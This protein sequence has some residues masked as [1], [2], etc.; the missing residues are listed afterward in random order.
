MPFSYAYVNY[1]TFF[2]SSRSAKQ[3]KSDFIFGGMTNILGGKSEVINIGLRDGFNIF[4][5]NSCQNHPH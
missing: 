3:A 1:D 4:N 2:H 5:G